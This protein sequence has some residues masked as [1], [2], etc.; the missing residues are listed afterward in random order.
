MADFAGAGPFAASAGGV[1]VVVVNTSSGLKAYD[2][3]CP[4]Q[5]ALLGEGELSAN[6]LVCRNHGWRFD[7]DSGARRGGPQCLVTCP[8]SIRG[9][10]VWIDVSALA[11]TH[12]PRGLVAAR[13]LADLPGPKPLPLLGNILQIDNNRLHLVLEKWAA[14]YGPMFTYRM[15]PQRVLAIADAALAEQLLRDRPDT[16][17]R[18]SIVEPVFREMGVAGVF[19]AEGA[20]WRAQRRLAM[21]ALSQRQI[22]ASFAALRTVVGRFEQRWQSYA[23]SGAELDVVAEMKR[24][25]VDVTTL[26]VFGH[27]VNTIEHGTDV[28]Q[29]NLELIFP[30]FNRRL[31][32]LVPTWRWLR[33]PADRRVDR[34]LA[35]LR[36]WLGVR[37]A[38]SR[39]RLGE[40]RSR[41]ERPENFIESMLTSRDA[42][43][44]P[45]S[46]DVIFGNAMTMLLAGEDT[47]AFTLAWAIH[48][49]CE[50]PRA[51]ARLR[52]ASD[53]V[54]M[55]DVAPFDFD[56]TGRLAYAGAVANEAMRMR[57]VAPTIFLENNRDVIIADVAVPARTWIVLLTRPPA[58]Q[59]TNFA[60]PETFWPER[61][62]EDALVVAPHE[63]G[64]QMP[65]GSGPR[66]CP[67]RSLALL[68]MKLVLSMIYRSFHVERVGD[69]ANVHEAFAFTMSPVGL[70]VRL[71]RR[72]G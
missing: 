13:V 31:F 47:T 61:W 68:E 25:T 45:F 21:Q 22:R 54:L 35:E 67:G 12:E 8:L 51:V 64:A 43:D 23:D 37:V 14:T 55:D 49:L 6:T 24:F 56:A 33:M 17:R 38:E 19:S 11:A 50:A 65:F 27:D 36:Q 15:G 58:L 66:I 59:H 28:I 70:K 71:R 63:T 20:A 34:A 53:A 30:T 42:D 16:Y 62:L 26:L 4:H 7:A 2:G 5:G 41:A 48:H 18:P 3:R 32:A 9:A 39:E 52:A 60:D 40:D 44:Q 29:R 69:A 57:P 1:D 46:D 10:D 72:S